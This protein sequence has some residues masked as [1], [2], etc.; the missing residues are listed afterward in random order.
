MTLCLCALICALPAVAGT[1]WDGGGANNLWSAA[2]NW[3]PDGLPANNGTSALAF[4]GS[5]RLAPDMDANWN[6]SSLTFNSGAGAFSLS[7]TSGFVLTIQGGGI[8][9][10]SASTE[11]INNAITLGTAQTWSATSGALSFGGNIANG[12]FL[13]TVSGGS[14]TTVNGVISDTGGLAKTGAGNLTLSGT[15]TYSGGTA[16]NAGTVS[17]S[18]NANLGVAAGGLTFNGGTLQVTGNIIGTRAITMTGAGTF[19]VALGSMMEQSGVIS[20]NGNLSLTSFGTLILSG[21]GSNGTGSTSIGGILA[22]RGTVTLGTG[23]LAFT[24]GVL[25]L[26]NGNFTRALGAAAGQVNMSTATNGAGFAAYGADRIVNLGGAGAIVTWGS[27]SFLAAGQVLYLGSL[28]AD[29]TVDFQ[30]GINLN[31]GNRSI[32]L[33]PGVGTT[34]DGKLSGVIS[35]TGASN[36]S[37]DAVTGFGAGSVILSN[38]GNSY[39]GTTTVNAGTLI[40]EASASG[41][42]GNTVLGSGAS[43][44]LIGN[45]SG[46]Y[47]AGLETNAAVTVSRNLRAQSGNTGVLTIGGSSASTSTFS[48]SLFLGTNAGVGKGVTLTS[49]AGGTT[50]FSGVIQDP[51]GVLGSGLVRTNGAGTVVLSGVNTY[52]GGTSIDGGTLSISQ[53]ANLGANAG[54]VAINAGTLAI[55]IGFS[56]NRVFTLGDIASTFLINPA[57]SFTITS[58]IGGAG[59]LNKNGTGTLTLSGANTYS[60]GSI[61]N[62]GT[63]TISSNGNL[64]AAATAVTVNAATLD[65][66]GTFNSTRNFTLGSAT[67]TVQVDP[68]F[69]FTD[70]GIFSG[71]GTLNKTGTGT[72]VLG[73]VNT[74]AGATNINA[75]TLRNGIA[76]AIQDSSAV[77]VASGATYDLNGFSETIGSLAGA[78]T[79][80]SG[81]VGALTL[82]AGGDNTSTLFSG[83]LQNGSGTVAFTKSGTGTL[84]LSGANTYTGLTTVS[85][86]ILLIQNSAALGTAAGGTTVNSGATLELQSNIAVGAEPLTLNGVGVSSFGALRNLSG[87]NS[88]AGAITL[89]SASAIYSDAGTLTLSGGIANGG[90][91]TTFG[92]A[93]NITQT[94]PV[95]GAGA[96][97]KNDGGTLTLGGAN[98]YSGG[99]TLNGGTTIITGT[100][101]LGATTGAATINSATLE[102]AATFTTPRNFILG[103]TTSTVQVDPTLTLTASGIFSGAGT[104]NKTGAGTMVLSGINT[105]TGPTNVTAGTLQISANDRILN[106]SDLNVSGGTFDVQTFS[107][108]LGIVTLASGTISGS[109]AGTLTG[110]SYTLQSGTVSAILAGNGAVTK[111]TAGTVILSGSNTFTGSTTIS[112]GTL[113]V[114]TNNALG[115]AASGTTVANGA[116]LKLNAVNYSTA[117]P[118]TLNGTGITNGGALTNSG[119][120]TFAGSINVATNATIGAGGGTLTLTGGISKSGTTLTISGGGT[121]NI[122][123]NGITGAAANSNVVFDGTTVVLSAASSYNG[124]TT[125]Q[126]SGTFKLGGNNLLPTTPQTGVT[127]NTSGTFDLASFSG[128]VASLTGDNTATVRN[129]VIGGTSTLTVNPAS[130]STTFAGII[131]GTNGGAQGN[132]ALQKNGAGTLVLTGANTFS[133]ATTVNGGTLSAAAPGGALASTSSLTINSGGTVLLGASNQIN[134]T[135]TITLAGGTFAKGNFSEG[136]ASTPG[137]GALTLTASGSQIDFGTGTVGVLTFDNFNPGAFAVMIANWSGTPNST[138]SPSTDRLI[139]ASDQSARLGSFSFSGYGPG[140]VEFNLGNGYYEITP[141]PE[142]STWLAG[143]LTLGVLGIQIALRRRRQKAFRA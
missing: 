14:N 124:S 115:T 28:T 133:G 74:Y 22:L 77:T 26:G 32:Q 6:I 70:S 1:T 100:G 110:S 18:S 46:A 50:T 125:I 132:V 10:N 91:T 117:E 113:Q 122:T 5:T 79:V 78:G 82:T 128:A 56:T 96:L 92:G 25:E 129:S 37:I 21:S 31:A 62:S 54:G 85:G 83:V 43:D 15:N 140:A 30:N 44:I 48:G 29:H 134:N 53:S 75:G 121:V 142:T 35:G 108:T 9:N 47:D 57:Q 107:E 81:A 138:G 114:N 42:A 126:N 51:T 136:S 141:V 12:G 112:A 34:P 7:S 93:G 58:A 102:A 139:F 89:A 72:L 127:I 97:V 55:T 103:N 105:Y 118:L 24:T 69:T 67:S 86:G 4:G 13:L 19:D 94:N 3:N 45:T 41:T 27:G 87:S 98:T 101:N 120:S 99:S 38:G 143:A 36:L 95:T 104:L 65:I 90:F 68:T 16:F 17:I 135:A 88:F 80:T 40:L 76:N 119:T 33:L 60:G 123:T 59:V 130:G 131:A 52:G 49:A 106:T 71:P 39:A 84:T 8:T 111:N 11:T 64:G 66:A 73:G 61:L 23:N 116:A 2:S 109:G 20:G 63:V 137:M